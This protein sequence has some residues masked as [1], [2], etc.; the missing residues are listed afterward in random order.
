MDNSERLYDAAAFYGLGLGD[1]YPLSS[2]NGSGTGDMLVSDTL[3]LYSSTIDVPLNNSGVI[4]AGYANNFFQAGYTNDP[5]T[6]LR[7]WYTSNAGA[8]VYIDGGFTNSKFGFDG[9]LDGVMIGVTWR[10]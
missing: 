8:N 7:I 10:N 2:I 5:V 9:T 1:Y 3:F 6:T 4:L